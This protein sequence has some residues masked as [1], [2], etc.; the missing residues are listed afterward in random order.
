MNIIKKSPVLILCMILLTGCMGHDTEA[1]P[2]EEA[3][4]SDSSFTAGEIE[5]LE[6]AAGDLTVWSVYWDNTD[7]IDIIKNEADSIDA[8]SIFAA[9]FQDGEIVIPDEALRML[10]RLQ[11]RGMTENSTVYLS[12]VNDVSRNGDVTQKDTDILKKLLATDSSAE[13]HAEDIVKLAE[14]NGFNGIEIDYEKIRDDI[15]LWKLFLNF[16]KKLIGLTSDAGLKVRIV[17]EPSTPVD[18]LEFPEGAEYVVMCYNLYGNGTVPGPKAD[19]AFLEEMYEKF[20]SLPDISYALANGGYIWEENSKKAVQCRAE[21]AEAAAAMN[22]ITPER[23]NESGVLHFSYKENGTEHTVW[24]ADETTLS[25][26]A[27][28]LNKLSGSKVPV[29]LWRL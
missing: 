10:G 2:E 15:D 11:R 5:A 19:M 20:R 3:S 29:S 28:K 9:S 23:D 4:G 18:K 26:W 14:D 21:E 12:V 22:D 17:L 25:M 27:E 1:A 24:Y 6:P 16:E 8:V 7:D 13:Q